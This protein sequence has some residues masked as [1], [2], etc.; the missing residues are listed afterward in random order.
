MIDLNNQPRVP[1]QL[2]IVRGQR[3]TAARLVPTLAPQT[4][5]LGSLWMWSRTK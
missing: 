3:L 5:A 4:T 1:W 2:Q